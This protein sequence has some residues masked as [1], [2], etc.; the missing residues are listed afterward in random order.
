MVGSNVIRVEAADNQDASLYLEA[1][2]PKNGYVF[3][4]LS[5][6]SDE[7][8]YFDDFY[9]RIEHNRISEETHYY[10][11]GQKI[12]GISSIAFNKL[13]N[14]YKFQANFSE[15]ETETGY[16]EFHL[17]MYDPQIGRWTGA[18]PYDE[19]ASPYVGMGNNPINAVDP[20]GGSVWSV[21]GPALATG[22]MNVI[23][24]WEKIENKSFWNGLG[25]FASGAVGGFV[26][27]Q[28][29]ASNVLNV[30][31]YGATAIGA[32]FTGIGNF[33][34]EYI[35]EHTSSGKIKDRSFEDFLKIYSKAYSTVMAGQSLVEN[36][37]AG[38]SSSTGK[39]IIDWKK[40]FKNGI[41]SFTYDYGASKAKGEW[42]HLS[43]FFAGA[44]G[45]IVND[46]SN[47]GLKE[48]LK[49]KNGI[50]KSFNKFTSGFLGE[51]ATS[52]LTYNTDDATMQW[53]NLKEKYSN[54]ALIKSTLKGTLYG[55]GYKKK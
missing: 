52:F 40:A 31:F 22:T 35:T 36:F 18:D 7:F 6:S 45:S 25:Y 10:A 8:V 4:Y 24:N 44:A 2:A 13:Q 51:V 33:G 39:K 9:N 3:I 43:S 26:T 32:V 42:G 16:N 15:E 37:T 49:S 34:V 17:R 46:L 47:Y 1:A 12:A 19:F 55:L 41:Q 30:G 27:Q 20:D 14:N 11:F 38:G 28:A 50:V 53:N 5:N 21:L 54:K 29:L 48:S 23:N